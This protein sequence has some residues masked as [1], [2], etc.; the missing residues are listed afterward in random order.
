MGKDALQLRAEADLAVAHT[1][2][3]RL[4]SHPVPGQDQTAA[5][6]GP[7]R[8]GKHPAESGEA[9]IP[10]IE[11]GM[12]SDFGVAMRVE[13][14]SGSLQFRAEFLVIEDFPVED[15]NHVSVRTPEWLITR[16]KIHNSQPRRTE[17]HVGRGELSLMIRTAM[18][19]RLKR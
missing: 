8:D 7:N 6:F 17:R 1:I 3:K 14:K 4:D 10:P 2:I 12:Q 13:M 19:D 18:G 11:I 16:F 9:G 15:Q 5:G